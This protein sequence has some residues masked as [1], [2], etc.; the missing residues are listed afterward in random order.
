MAEDKKPAIEFPCAYPIK[1]MGLHGDDFAA[2][3]LAIVQCHDP[4]I[5]AEHLSYKPS[6][7]GKYV[8]VNV[9]ITATGVAQLQALFD[10]LKA[11]GRVAMVL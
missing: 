2:V 5:T 9:T 11:S 10:D 1:V 7:N 3:V 6:R 4:A 8:S